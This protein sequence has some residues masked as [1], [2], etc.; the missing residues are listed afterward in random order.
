M[1]H[2]FLNCLLNVSIF[3]YY[4]YLLTSYYQ[5]L[6]NMQLLF[7]IMCSIDKQLYTFI[8]PCSTLIF[9]VAAINK[10][11]FLNCRTIKKEG[12]GYKEKRTVFGFLICCPFVKNYILLKI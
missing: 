7:N 4:N 3:F 5:S 9:R 2:V 11:Y 6:I 12:G 1:T 8:N 10:S